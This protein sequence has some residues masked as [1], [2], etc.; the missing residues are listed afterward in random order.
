MTELKETLISRCVSKIRDLLLSDDLLP[1]DKI[2]G[3]YLKSYL[4]CGLS[5]IREALSRLVATGVVTFVDNEGF[6]VALL[7]ESAIID[8]YTTYAKIEKLLF[9]ESILNHYEAWESNVVSSLFR[10]SKVE[11]NDIKVEYQLW[12]HYNDKFHDALVSGSLLNGLDDLYKNLAFKKVWIHNKVYGCNNKKLITLS[13]REHNKI[14]EL[15]LL[16]DEAAT[17]LLYKHTMNG[18]DLLLRNFKKKFMNS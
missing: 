9:S 10:L 15:A 1:G 17:S 6:K 11:N 5:P 4:N 2:K 7:S 14:A 8:F 3:D 13:H 12:S 16:G 18:G